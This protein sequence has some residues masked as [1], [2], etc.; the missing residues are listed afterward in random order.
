MEIS[1]AAGA[2]GKPAYSVTFTE[3]RLEDVRA[4]LNRFERIDEKPF[5]AAAAV[6]DFNQGAY[7]LFAQPAVRALASE[8]SAKLQRT[9]HPQR[10]QRWAFSDLNP[11]LAWVA[12]LA[13]AAKE[14]RQALPAD[15]PARAPERIASELVAASLDYYRGVRDALSEAA[16]FQIYGALFVRE[17]ASPARP[18][19]AA[20]PR[21][22]RYVKDALGAI[23]H[24][25]YPEALAR[26]AVLVGRKD[27]PLPL[28][29][30]EL[31]AELSR[32]YG[33][34]VPP[35]PLDE[36]RRIR[37]EQE[38]VAR[39]EPQK[40]LETLPAL[41]PEAA[42]RERLLTLLDRLLAD[43]RIQAVGAS[44]EQLAMLARIRDVLGAHREAPRRAA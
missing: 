17:P 16:F 19:E 21:E 40:A 23:D 5:E 18:E 28:S 36:A 11:W 38:I 12:P 4:R 44:A 25:G 37:G 29:R 9:L 13:K 22:L 32:E 24:G 6:A 1:Q 14:F 20:D 35:V 39:Y 2:D 43:R 41:L 3:R 27:E 15:H 34:L 10:V 33:E 26:V 7:E 8:S 30:V 42:D 31:K